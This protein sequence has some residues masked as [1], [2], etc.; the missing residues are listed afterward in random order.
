M[1]KKSAIGIGLHLS[2]RVID[3]QIPNQVSISRLKELLIETFEV[4]SIELPQSFELIVL[5]KPIHLTE[6]QLLA[7]FPIGDGDQLFIKETVEESN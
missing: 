1:R 3:L 7:D 5:N 4:L 2:N 6:N